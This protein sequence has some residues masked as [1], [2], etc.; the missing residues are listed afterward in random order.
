MSL[1]FE[2]DSLANMT[3]IVSGF[4][5]T[6]WFVILKESRFW[7][8][9][10]LAVIALFTFMIAGCCSQPGRKSLCCNG[11]AFFLS[12]LGLAVI[13]SYDNEL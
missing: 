7:A 4:A 6:S 8:N 3:K 12:N 5:E 11:F 2:G 9:G 10:G 13:F 1:Y